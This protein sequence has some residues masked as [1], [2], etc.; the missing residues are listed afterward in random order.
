MHDA[1]SASSRVTGRLGSTDADLL[2]DDA[3]RRVEQTKA[4]AQAGA[5]VANPSP[6]PQAKWQKGFVVGEDLGVD[7]PEDLPKVPTRLW[8]DVILRNM[9]EYRFSCHANAQRKEMRPRPNMGDSRCAQ[10]FP[11][12]PPGSELNEAEAYAE[13]LELKTISWVREG[14]PKPEENMVQEPL[15]AKY[16]AGVPT[17]PQENKVY[18]GEDVPM[19]FVD[20]SPAPKEP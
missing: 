4:V 18:S 14:G 3:G 12:S 8:R 1:K 5:L 13:T 19:R 6:P 10:K 15:A 11:R 20:Y 7:K 16:Y 9:G 2:R 17:V